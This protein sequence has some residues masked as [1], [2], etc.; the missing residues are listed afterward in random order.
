ME[1]SIGIFDSGVGGLSVWREIK[2]LIPKSSLIY[3]S[4]SA[5]VPYGEKRPKQLM[6]LS[7]QICKF[8]LGKNA[9]IIVIACNTATAYCIQKLRNEFDLPF[10]GT[11]PPVKPAAAASKTGKIAIM[12][13]P[14]TIKSH[15]LSNLISNFA[16][17]VKI[18]KIPAYG[19]EDQVEEGKINRKKT[20]FL[21][22]K[23]LKPAV[24]AE[25]DGLALGCTHYPFL[26]PQIKKITKNKLKIFDPAPAV[27]AQVKRVL[28][29]NGLFPN[30]GE[31]DLFYTT[32]DPKQFSLLASKLL[33]R[34]ITAEK[35]E[36]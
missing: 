13:T 31:V 23:Y 14:A 15:Y 36:I 1:N 10:V 30:F 3:F 26:L 24:S 6:E 34:K 28:I 20:V 17:G 9:K 5:H 4:D 18:L 8:L 25:V 2:K 7:K 29:K 16:N 33:K 19:L 32:G 22:T 27:A 35:I 12:A 11:V 21:L